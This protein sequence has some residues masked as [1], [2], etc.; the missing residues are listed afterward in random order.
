MKKETIG[1]V[2]SSILGMLTDLN[3]KL[4]HHVISPEELGLFLKKQN[5]WGQ[6]NWCANILTTERQ[7]HL[8]FFGQE[9]DLSEFEKILKEYGQKKIREWQELGLEPHFLPRMAMSQDANFIGW[10]VKPEDWYY[11]KVAEGKILRNIAGELEIDKQAFNLEGITVLVDTRLK[12]SYD[13]GK[14]MFKNDNLLGSIILS[15]RNKGKIAQYDYCP[16]SSRFGVSANEWEKEI[17]PVLVLKLGIDKAQL[18]LE[19]TIE[20]NVIPQLYLHIPR[21]KDGETNTWA[22]YEEYFGG[23]SARLGGGRSGCGGLADVACRSS[24]VH[25]GGW[26]FRPLVVLGT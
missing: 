26:A 8:N 25:W 12:P 11:E 5:P 18:R 14:Q 19:R 1:M 7:C 9:F 6:D 24:G 20:A 21:H 16:Q 2:P 4:Q 23:A 3:I 17:K 22:W 15:L 13:D 10:K